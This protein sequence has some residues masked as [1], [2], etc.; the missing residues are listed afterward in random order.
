MLIVKFAQKRLGTNISFD[1]A[2][3]EL[4]HT[5][6]DKSGERDF[7]TDYAEIGLG[8]RRVFE[9]KEWFRNVGALWCI[10]GVASIGIDIYNGTLGLWSGFWLVIGAGCLIYYF[11]SKT[12]YTVIETQNGSLW[13]IEDKQQSQ[14]VSEIEKR[15]KDRLYD[16]YGALNLDNDADQELAKIEWLVKQKVLTRAEADLQVAQIRSGNLAALPTPEKLIN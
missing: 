10:I 9:N 15:R 2:A 14:I 6:H 16:L 11:A 13:V 7:T 3:T 5:I 1:F 8:K 12:A 4:T